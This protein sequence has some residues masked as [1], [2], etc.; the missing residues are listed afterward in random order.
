[1]RRGGSSKDSRRSNQVAGLASREALL[2]EGARRTH[3]DGARDGLVSLACHPARPRAT[4]V[5]RVQTR[6]SRC[7]SGA[8]IAALLS[9]PWRSAPDRPPSTLL[10]RHRAAPVALKM[11]KARRLSHPIRRAEDVAEDLMEANDDDAERINARHLVAA[12]PTPR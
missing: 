5:V 12:L 7:E 1:M 10:K 6:P 9:L 4:R 8:R 2:P 3:K 11:P